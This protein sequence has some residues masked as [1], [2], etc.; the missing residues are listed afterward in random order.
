M[1]KSRLSRSPSSVYVC[2]FALGDGVGFKERETA[3]FGFRVYVIGLGFR[4]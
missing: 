3:D 2:V 4:V 1:D